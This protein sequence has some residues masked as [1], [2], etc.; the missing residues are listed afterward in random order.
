MAGGGGLDASELR[1]SKQL[2]AWRALR[3]AAGGTNDDECRA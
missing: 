3:W 1:A 2:G